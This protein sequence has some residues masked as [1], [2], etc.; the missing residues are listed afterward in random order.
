MTWL[1][2]STALVFSILSIALLGVILVRFFR[3]PEIDHDR[4]TYLL[5]FPNDLDEQRIVA[6]LRSVSGLLYDKKGRFT[7]VKSIAFET[8][9]TD[10]GIA[11]RMKVPWQLGDYIAGQL[12]TLA[13]GISVEEDDDRPTLNWS[14]AVELGLTHPFRTLDIP[15]ASDLSASLLT[16]PGPLNPGETV[17]VQ[18]V[19][20]PAPHEKPPAKDLHSRTDESTAKVILTGAELAH[21]DE[22]EDR[23][24]KLSQPNLQ[25]VGRIAAYAKTEPRAVQ[26]VRQTNGALHAAESQYTQFAHQASRPAKLIERINNA[27]AP[28]FFPAQFNLSEL[29]ALLAWPIGS[30]F[31]AGLPQGPTRH[32]YATEDVPRTGIVL[33]H[34][35]YPGHERPIALGYAHAL[36]HTYY[37]G[38]TGTGK[39]TAMANNFAQVVSQGFGGIV[40][41]ASNSDSN[42]SLFS[43]ALSYVPADRLNDVIVM[44]V[45]RSRNRPVGFNVLDQGNPRVVV[46]QISDTLGYLYSD[47]LSGVWR[48]KLM[49]HGLY[50]LADWPGATFLDLVPLLLPSTDEEKGWSERVVTSV[51]DPELQRFWRDWRKLPESERATYMQPLVNRSWQ[52]TS[53]SE[54]RNIIGQPESSFKMADVLRD[55]KILLVSLSGLPSETSMLLGT[56]LVNALWTAAQTM[57]PDKPNFLYLDEFQLMT[58]LPMGLDDMLARARKHKLP[59]VLG[60]QYLEDLPTEL[61]NAVIN[62]A[63]SRVIF[64]SS[65]KEA[66]TWMNEMGKQHVTDNDFVRIRKYEAIAQLVTDSGIGTPVTLKSLA[67]IPTTGVAREAV[68]MSAERYGRDLKTIESQVAERREA[69][70]KRRRKAPTI[71]VREG[72]E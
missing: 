13:P 15:S 32:L 43:R 59:M 44:D 14:R 3:Q 69:R 61:K 57:T 11:H 63:R 36:Q 5:T 6:W 72:G 23:R 37:G 49:F 4:K 45:N 24:K 58:R 66:R 53:R 46:D 52:L 51:K 29:A 41:D 62:N 16:S 34:S 65:A 60:T 48:R 30:P 19:V 54:V 12:R 21:R 40:I 55:N 9:T 28:M 71:G 1:F 70:G 26:L 20:T 42:E 56:L 10:T 67:P 64:Q 22:L 38:S 2:V 17:L 8:W 7:G 47:M 18:W 27:A 25:A 50:T 33:G 39:S 68:S 31:V 35:N